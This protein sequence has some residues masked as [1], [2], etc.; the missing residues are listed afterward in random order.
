MQTAAE[1]EEMLNEWEYAYP[2]L[3]PKTH[4][5]RKVAPHWH[6]RLTEMEDYRPPPPAGVLVSCGCPCKHHIPP[7]TLVKGKVVSSLKVKCFICGQGRM[8]EYD[9]PS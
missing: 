8:L 7:T 4:K 3:T 9:D 1:I 2:R 6:K 5:V